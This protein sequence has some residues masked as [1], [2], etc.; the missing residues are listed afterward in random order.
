[1]TIKELLETIDDAKDLLIKDFE[2]IH[3]KIP[4]DKDLLNHVKTM[5]SDGIE[6]SIIENLFLDDVN[7]P[8]DF[9]KLVLIFAAL[10]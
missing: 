7:C 6:D 9:Y 4:K 10:K 5:Y 3:K 2:E 1:M 8:S